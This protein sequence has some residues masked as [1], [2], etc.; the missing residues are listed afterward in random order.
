MKYG[1]FSS[2]VQLGAELHAGT[3]LLQLYGDIGL[4]PLVRRISRIRSLVDIRSMP[5][6]II[7]EFVRVES[8]F[9]IFKIQHFNAYKKFVKANFGFAVALVTLLIV[10]AYMA[11]SEIPI[12]LTV[13]VIAL[14]IFPAPIT[15]AV[16]WI[17]ASNSSK[18]I[19]E[20]AE[21]L[22]RRAIQAVAGS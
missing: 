3:A 5:V 2:L 8:D 16:L 11:D 13:G 1:D 12:E 14:S 21:R 10:L 7:D 9:E 20:R 18:Q 4:A 22:E 19:R 15:V 6:D 17:D